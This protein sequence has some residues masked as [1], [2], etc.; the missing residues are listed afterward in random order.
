MNSTKLITALAFIALLLTAESVMAQKEIKI[1]DQIW[2]D[3]NL[4]VDTFRNGEHIMEAKTDEEWVAAGEAKQPA[5]CYYENK[6]E[7]GAKFGKLYNWYAVGDPRGLAPKGWKVPSKDNWEKLEKYVRLTDYTNEGLLFLGDWLCQY[8]SNKTGFTAKPG[9]RRFT[10]G[11]FS[12]SYNNENYGL[13]A[14][15]WSTTVRGD[16]TYMAYYCELMSSTSFI[17][18]DGEKTPGMSV[19][20][21]KE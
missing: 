9:G 18:S 3:R 1:G 2:M 17:T 5:W 11:D 20:C 15:F 10:G 13:Q 12:G 21:I 4:N 8:G 7:N 19:R 6:L 16:L 14:Y